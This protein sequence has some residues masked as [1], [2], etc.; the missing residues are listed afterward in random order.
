[1][2]GVG[3]C[4]ATALEELLEEDRGLLLD[5][6]DQGGD[7]DR[8][9]TDSSVGLSDGSTEEDRS[10]RNIKK[11]K[12]SD[13]IVTLNTDTDDDTKIGTTSLHSKGNDD[14]TSTDSR[15]KR[16]AMDET[17]SKSILES[18]GNAVASTTFDNRQ[19]AKNE[20]SSN[21]SSKTAV[22]ESETAI[23]PAA[24]LKGDIEHYTNYQGKWQIIVKNAVILT[25]N[26]IKIGNGKSGNSWRS[27]RVIDWDEGAADVDDVVKNGKRQRRAEEKKWNTFR[28]NG[29]V[30]VLAYD[31]DT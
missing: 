20:L 15:N 8:D 14:S 12:C 18:Y 4:L 21:N 7:V 10:K 16:D 29:T 24:L 25:R 5:D 28:L 27:R 19:K 26:V 17:M 2:S 30:E 13:S 23:A 22:G 3:R 1:M 6:H 9:G 31:D 11:N